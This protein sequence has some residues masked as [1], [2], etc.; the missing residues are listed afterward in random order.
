LG[1]TMVDDLY[2]VF[3]IANGRLHVQPSFQAPIQ[4]CK[5]LKGE[6]SLYH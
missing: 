1:Q 2:P 3:V 4:I 5:I 6:V